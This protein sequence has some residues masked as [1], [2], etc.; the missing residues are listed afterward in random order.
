MAE[1]R[2]GRAL[3]GFADRRSL[4]RA[5]QE[6]L[7]AASPDVRIFAE[8]FLAERSTIDL[9][10]V[11]GEGE[12][13]SI[14]FVEAGEDAAGFT[15]ALAD[16]TWLRSRRADLLK[17]APGLGLEPSAEP[18]AALFCRE[19]GPE[20][21]AAADNFPAGTVQLWCCRGMHRAGRS[22]LLIESVSHGPATPGLLALATEPKV[23]PLTAPPSPSA[24]RTGLIDADLEP[25]RTPVRSFF[26]GAPAPRDPPTPR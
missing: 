5:L 26:A 9:L 13:V 25:G 19:L 6:A 11:G 14:R 1:P 8:G 21:R 17:L 7:L 16:L 15:R 12:L 3:E 23:Q 18:R 20:T 24:F 22:S 2:A 10:G 4:R